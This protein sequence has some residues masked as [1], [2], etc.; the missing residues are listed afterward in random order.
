MLIVG[1]TPAGVKM[2]LPHL[3]APRVTPEDLPDGATKVV[4]GFVL[5]MLLVVAIKL[6]STRLT[7]ART[8]REE[9]SK[10]E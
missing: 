7:V 8:A 6:A 4:L 2:E 3:V 10:L 9:L 5:K 1:I